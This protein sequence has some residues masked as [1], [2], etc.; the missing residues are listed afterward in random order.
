M[1]LLGL[2]QAHLNY[3][4]SPDSRHDFVPNEAM[5]PSRR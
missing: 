1:Q 3:Y 2:E 4:G 5:N